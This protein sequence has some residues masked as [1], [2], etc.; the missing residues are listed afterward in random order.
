MKRLITLCLIIISGSPVIFS[1]C[2]EKETIIAN[3]QQDIL[4]RHKWK[5]YQTRTVIT[6]NTTNSIV[7]DTITQPEICNQ[8]SLLI[9]AA[10]SLVR[11]NSLC[12]N[13]D[14][15]NEG[16]WFL[17]AD[18]T[19]SAPIW[20]RRSY[21]SGYTFYNF[22]LPF[23]KMKL[24]TEADFQLL[25]YDGFTYGNVTAYNIYFLKAVD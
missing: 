24:L 25:A 4:M 23:G 15:I 3:S 20:Q 22:G 17:K 11:R 13:P 5:H 21:G 18:S 1:S 12:L 10:D 16:R 2:T 8:N 6:D 14:P 7:T 9:F 19:F